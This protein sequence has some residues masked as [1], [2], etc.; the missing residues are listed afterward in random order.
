MALGNV[1][2][3]TYPALEPDYYLLYFASVTVEILF[4]YQ[5][6]SETPGSGGAQN[7]ATILYLL[8]ACYL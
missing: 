8:A 3:V 1:S 6:S 4:I 2:R 5:L 7:W